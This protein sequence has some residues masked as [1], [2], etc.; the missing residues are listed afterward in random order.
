MSDCGFNFDS[1]Y[2][3]LLPKQFFSE[4][5]PESVPAP[6]LVL[7]NETLAQSLGLS[8]AH[9]SASERAAL[10]AGNQ[11]PTG[12]KP[13]AQAYAV[14]QFGYF[15]MLGD[16]RAHVLGEQI[17]PSGQRFDLQLKGSG[18]TPYSR[19][20]DGKAALGPMLREYIISEAMHQLAVPT[21]RSLAVVTTGELVRRETALPG[22]VLTRVARSHLRVGT[23]EFAAAQGD[24]PA[25]EALLS[26]TI[27]RHYPELT[28]S[29]GQARAL[30]RAVMNRQADL[31]VH[32]LR[33][34]FVHGVMNTDNMTLS[35]ETIDYGPCAFM[36]EYDP[37]TVF[38]SI[39]Q[40][41]RYAYAN[42]PKI[43]HWN[44]A[45]LAEALLPAIDQ[46]PGEAIELAKETL[47]EFPALYQ[48]KWLAMMRSKLGLIGAQSADE[49]L[50]GDL[51]SWL[52]TN[53]ADYTNTFRALS[54]GEQP[55]QAIY[56]QDQF[57]DWYQRWQARLA[58]NSEP[59]GAAFVLM[60]SVNPAVIPRNHQVEQALTAAN[61]GEFKP[62]HDLLAALSNPYE[63]H[64]S[65]KPYQQP[66]KASERVE[67]TF[68]GT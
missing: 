37:D 27:D 33:V 5:P 28:R 15:T 56:Q 44:L 53:S 55:T 31:I 49:S 64:E 34:G 24:L 57:N 3:A 39:D 13:V 8:F 25:L 43:A 51:L 47:G 32:W 63:D 62:V 6:A 65:L 41:G 21:T 9:L 16:G 7:F 4:L 26:Y 23:F 66:P 59:R 42:Q 14:H 67:H 40:D 10:L 58:Q 68:C 35:G 20:G 46:E 22:A 54:Q 60:R 48:H 30:L 52:H 1:T 45:R 38:S 36:D 29:A 11:L 61:G 50:I 17:T 19:R 2:P 12:A 18:R